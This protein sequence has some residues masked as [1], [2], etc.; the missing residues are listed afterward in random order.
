MP[1]SWLR[2]EAAKERRENPDL[3][4]GHELMR[5]Q[6][7]VRQEQADRAESLRQHAETLAEL[8]AIRRRLEEGK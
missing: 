8:K 1:S 5:R 7:A 4:S 2:G 3:I 6:A